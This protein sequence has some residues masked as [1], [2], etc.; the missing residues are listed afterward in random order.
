MIIWP[1]TTPHDCPSPCHW[2]PVIECLP[3]TLGPLPQLHPEAS[4][5]GLLPQRPLI[6]LVRKHFHIEAK[7]A[8][9][10]LSQF[11]SWSHFFSPLASLVAQ[12][13]KNLPVMQEPQVRFLGQKAPLEKGMA[14][15]SSIL[16]WRIPWTEEPGGLQSIGS[17]RARCDW[18][19]DT[20]TWVSTDDR[21]APRA[22]GTVSITTLDGRRL[23]G[24]PFSQPAHFTCSGAPACPEDHGRLC[25]YCWWRCHTCSDSSASTSFFPKVSLQIFKD[26]CYVL[27]L[28]LFIF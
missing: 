13:V 23:R 1:R 24:W 7:L 8:S 21:W 6:S 11:W 9:T 16:A 19:T 12:M 3:A 5:P 28:N 14:T 25:H 18:V 10:N 27:S 20:F 22:G 26:N 4:S 17:Q 15:H 2:P